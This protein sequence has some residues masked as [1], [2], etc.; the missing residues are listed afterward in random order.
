MGESHSK[1][2]PSATSK[3]IA[4]RRGSP[5][6]GVDGGL[7]KAKRSPSLP[8]VLEIDSCVNSDPTGNQAV[9]NNA[10]RLDSN[11]DLWNDGKSINGPFGKVPPATPRKPPAVNDYEKYPGMCI[12]LSLVRDN[13][14]FLWYMC[15]CSRACV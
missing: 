2:N 7:R 3:R 15:T 14:M 6:P 8:S 1:A 11:Q 12:A 4:Q 13:H 9:W 10:K 5:A